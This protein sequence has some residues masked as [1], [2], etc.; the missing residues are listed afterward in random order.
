MQLSK[1]FKDAVG[2]TIS[3]MGLV[4]AATGQINPFVGMSVFA[5]RFLVPV[6]EKTDEPPKSWS[7]V[8]PQ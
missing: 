5:A 4:Y 1:K 6:H 7:Q 2:L 3:T 8:A